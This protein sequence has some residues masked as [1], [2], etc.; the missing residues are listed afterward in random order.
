M[1]DRVAEQKLHLAT[2]R[3]G[4]PGVT[5]LARAGVHLHLHRFVRI[6]LL[7]DLESVVDALHRGN[8]GGGIGR[9][10]E[11]PG[12][13]V[14]VDAAT[15]PTAQKAIVVV[16]VVPDMISQRG[17]GTLVKRS[18]VERS[19]N[20]VQKGD[21]LPEAALVIFSQKVHGWRE[22]R[23]NGLFPAT[24]YWSRSGKLLLGANFYRLKNSDMKTM[25]THAFIRSLSLP[26]L[27]VAALALL[28]G[29]RPVNKDERN[30]ALGGYDVMTFH[31][32]DTP[33][34][35]S[36]IF[37]YEWRGAIWRFSRPAHLQSFRE[38]PERWAPQFGGYCS[39]CVTEGNLTDF[40]A[41]HYVVREGR[42]YLFQDQ[43]T[44]ETWLEDP[45]AYIVQGSS[46]FEAMAEREENEEAAESASS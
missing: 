25:T 40:D 11:V 41:K 34:L 18:R 24:P 8:R 28:T 16:E 12:A 45:E 2:Q 37:A 7:K 10:G 4:C 6:L 33:L 35:G 19:R 44:K 15:L 5:A 30:V 27:A 21:A 3:T 23:V 43:A 9:H 42:L 39:L 17:P 36:P 32:E 31:T 20:S 29:F 13:G 38:E 26:L 14:V 1:M 22:T 46:E